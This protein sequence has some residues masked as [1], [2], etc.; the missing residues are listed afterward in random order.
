MSRARAV[1]TYGVRDFIYALQVAGI[2]PQN[3]AKVLLAHGIEAS[4]QWKGGFLLQMKDARLGYLHGT[5]YTS[6]WSDANARLDYAKHRLEFTEIPEHV[7][8]NPVDCNYYLA[9]PQ[10]RD[11]LLG[12]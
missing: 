8:E 3:V 11:E 12:S 6:D 2:N 10:E 4:G 5:A 7:D 9:H 1:N